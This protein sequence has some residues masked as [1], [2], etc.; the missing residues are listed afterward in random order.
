MMSNKQCVTTTTISGVMMTATTFKTA[1]LSTTISVAT[2]LP[3]EG[4]K[5]E[6]PLE[7]KASYVGSRP[8]ENLS[9]DIQFYL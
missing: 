9:L 2:V 4:S 7:M 6:S 8:V 1:T 5:L 3:K